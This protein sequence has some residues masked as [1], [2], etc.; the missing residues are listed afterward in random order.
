MLGSTLSDRAEAGKIKI[1]A[2]TRIS[3]LAAAVIAS[4]AVPA[5]AQNYSDGFAFLKAIR[6]RDGAKVNE[7]VNGT[8]ATIVNHRDPGS[9]DGALHI[10]VRGRDYTWLNFLLR[11]GARPDLQNKDGVTALQL[12]AQIGWLQGAERLLERGANP[13]LANNR[14]ETPL[15]LA[16]QGRHL[17][18]V[19]LLVSQRAD[20]NISDSLQGYSAIDY[21]RQDPR[22]AQ[23]LRELEAPRTETTPSN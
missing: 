18:M 21:A 11:N 19:R 2:R 5:V 17:P 23:I 20:P 12:A 14:G 13:N 15:I 4:L 3:L 9:G 10:L 8:G 1:V 22:T 7:F 16:V 6:E